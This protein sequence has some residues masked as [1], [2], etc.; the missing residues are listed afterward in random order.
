MTKNK[1]KKNTKYREWQEFAKKD[2]IECAVCKRVKA[3]TVDHIIPQ[4]FQLQLDCA[5]GVYED[6]EN[7]QYLCSPCNVYKSNRINIADAK[8]IELLKKYV[9]RL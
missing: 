8:S 3:V 9:N 6:E 4:T 1:A 7:F 5:D 2:D